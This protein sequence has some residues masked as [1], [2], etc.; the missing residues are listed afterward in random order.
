MRTALLRGRLYDVIVE[1]FVEEHDSH[2]SD[3]CGTIASV[4]DDL[5]LHCASYA[6]LE[7]LWCQPLT[8][9]YFCTAAKLT[10]QIFVLFVNPFL[11]EIIFDN[12][13]LQKL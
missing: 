1:V 6:A 11:A 5:D 3:Q 2:I 12:I 4:R 8:Y 10:Q 13:L 7:L 9:R